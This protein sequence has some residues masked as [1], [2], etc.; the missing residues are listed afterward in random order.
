METAGDST[1]VVF[2]I[3]FLAECRSAPLPCGETVGRLQAEIRDLVG[4]I[5]DQ[6]HYIQGLH[7][8]QAQKLPQIPQTHLQT[9][10]QYQDCSEIFKDGNTASGLYVI[11]PDASPHHFLVFCD[12]SDGGGWTVFQRRKDGTE[13]F[14]RAWVEYKHGFGDSLVDGEFWMG[15]DPLHYLTSQGNYDLKINLEDFDGNQRYA[16]YNNFKVDDEKDQYQLH[17]G[18]YHGNAGDA[19]PE[20]HPPPSKQWESPDAGH[21]GV[22]FSTY[23]HSNQEDEDKCLRHEMSGWWFSKCESGNL[24]GHYYNGPYQAIMDDGVVWY[25]WHGWWY[26][27]KSVVMMIRASDFHPSGS[28]VEQT[29]SPDKI[30][31]LKGFPQLG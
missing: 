11:R 1:L 23:D 24:N 8:S 10:D 5:N 26:S 31:H 9:G 15:N 27:I 28:D 4:V 19:L 30:N 18:E 12:M 6:H 22:K 29:R 16:K 13:S 21:H 17:L 20:A 2:A 25:T 14:D 3:L 7:L